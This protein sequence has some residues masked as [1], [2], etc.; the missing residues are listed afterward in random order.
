VV[1]TWLNFRVLLPET[2]CTCL[3][4]A[5]LFTG[6]INE[7]KS[8]LGSCGRISRDRCISAVGDDLSFEK[9]QTKKHFLVSCGYHVLLLLIAY[10]SPVVSW[11]VIMYSG[12]SKRAPSGR[13]VTWLAKHIKRNSKYA[14]RF[15][16]R[17]MTFSDM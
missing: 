6:E 16:L 14:I 5:T 2:Y 4:F 1:L 13:V 7:G 12:H 11:R 10:L 15:G 17:S 9:K 3:R 8:M